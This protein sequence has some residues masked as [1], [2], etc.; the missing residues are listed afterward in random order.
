MP[1]SRSFALP[2][3]FFFLAQSLSAATIPVGP[4]PA[5]IQTAI[6][7]A[8][9]GDTIQLSAGTYVQQVQVVSKS[10]TIVG[11]GENATIIQAPAAATA[12]TQFFSFNSARFW[13]VLMIDNQ[14]APTPQSVNIS[15]LTV[16]GGTQQDTTI[17]PA[18]SPG[19]YGSSDRF[20]AVGYHDAGGTLTNIHA[21]NTRQSANFNELAGGGIV[22]A[23]SAAAVTFNVTG[24]L[25]DFYQRGGIDVR[26]AT[27]TANIANTT[28]NR[29]Y[30]LTPNTITAVPNGIQFSVGAVG[31]VSN[32][33]ISGNICTVA[34]TQATGI[35][36]FGAG[37]NLLLS[38][39]A[40]DN[41]DIAIAAI[42]NGDGLQISDNAVNFTG[43]VGVSPVEGIVVQDTLGLTTL[44][45]NTMT[46]IPGIAM[47][48]ID[49]TGTDEPF[50]LSGNHFVGGQTGL[51]VTGVTTTG[52]QVTMGSDT[53]AG[54]TG[55][56]ITESTSPHNIWPSTQS[57]SFDGLLSG[58]VTFA[59]FNQILA[60]IFDQH[61]DAALGL[62]LDFIPP[63]P[64]TLTA[65]SP[66]NGPATG[67]NTITITGT[68]FLSS[69]TTVN[70]GATPATNVVVVSDT[71]ITATAPAGTGIV[72][73]TVT[74]PFGTTP[75]VPADAYTYLSPGLAIAFAP[76]SI[77]AGA[78]ATLTIKLSNPNPAPATLL[79]NLVDSFP[80]GLFVA[81]TPNASTTCSAGVP[82]A[83]AAS[84][85]LIAGAG[86]PAREVHRAGR[87]DQ[88]DC[89][90]L[91]ER[92]RGGRAADR[93]RQQRHVGN[94]VARRRA[95]TADAA[96]LAIA[97]APAAIFAADEH[98]D[99]HAEQPEPGR[100][101]PVGQP[102]RRASGQ[103]VRRGDAER[104][105][106]LRRRRAGRGR[107][108]ERHAFGAA[109]P[110]AGTC[111]LQ[112]AVTSTVANIYTD[113]L[114]AGSLQTISTA[115]PR[116]M[117][118]RPARRLSSCRYRRRRSRRSARPA[119]RQRAARR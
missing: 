36:P 107:D 41:N 66:A 30:T 31:S 49:D 29:G 33:T 103:P 5:S 43:A 21:T 105:D 84:I 54:T 32:S 61:N 59:E 60:K 74:T 19:F 93:S 14:A 75:V 62:V 28:V 50:Q 92:A 2:L 46:N 72:D 47:D 34:G 83:T 77:V 91:L 48:L 7:S 52:P 80:S 63:S 111:T 3:F 89:E 4:P 8:S 24:S 55:N 58:H 67:G 15:A 117:P 56:Y 78:T 13:C 10:L 38:G 26:G 9:N 44:A 90:H 51:S 98:D 104:I 97:F 20:F 23:S 102:V 112:V 12:L 37:P 45:A 101:I 79:A 35:I 18:P 64:P 110:A 100:G 6:N 68:G 81:P 82:I 99:D 70:F 76:A 22:N 108:V 40:F 53:F 87:R 57:V 118:R 16:D 11:A 95:G 25:V 73:V 113:T 17:L 69:N 1:H 86:I 65:V 109:I 85:M 96:G 42:N 116:R 94:R 39:N 71:Q 115:M 119:G 106:D 88:R 27:L 114:P